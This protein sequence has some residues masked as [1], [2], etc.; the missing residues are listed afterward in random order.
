MTEPTGAPT[1]ARAN[2]IDA[3]LPQGV[4]EGPT[5]LR[6]AALAPSEGDL[7]VPL[8]DTTPPPPR[9]WASIEATLRREG[10][11]RGR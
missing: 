10:R 7:A 2:E 5:S 11:I 3:D 9:V 6:S 4:G 8:L 1:A